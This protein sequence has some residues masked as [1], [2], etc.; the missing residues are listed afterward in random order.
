MLDINMVGGL[1]DIF[2]ILHCQEF[3][4]HPIRRLIDFKMKNPLEKIRLNIFSDNPDSYNLFKLNYQYFNEIKS[5]SHAESA[6]KDLFENWYRFMGYTDNTLGLVCL[7]SE[8]IQL[9]SDLILSTKRICVFHPFTS[10]HYKLLP[11]TVSKKDFIDVMIDKYNYIVVLLG[12]N[13]PHLYFNS[14]LPFRM[15][16]TFDYERDDLL[17]LVNKDS[18]SRIGYYIT[19]ELADKII[20][21]HSAYIMLRNA[22]LPTTKQNTLALMWKDIPVVDRTHY[23]WKGLY[24]KPN[25][26]CTYDKLIDIEKTVDEFMNKEN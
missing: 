11:N 16:E 25:M 1:G 23:F 18:I 2:S 6:G 24:D 5:Y 26:V 20:S 22:Y 7:N 14:L 15:D 3:D 21:V 4:C 19:T 8:E 17:N 13:N 10:T 9:V 12:K